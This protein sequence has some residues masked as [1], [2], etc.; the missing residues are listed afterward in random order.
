MASAETQRKPSTDP[1]G[2]GRCVT[3]LQQLLGR[4]ELPAT[5]IAPAS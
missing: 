2:G 1:A 4:I 3:V 5:D